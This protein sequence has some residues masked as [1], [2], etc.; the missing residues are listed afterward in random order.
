MEWTC[1]CGEIVV[2]ERG[3]CES[4]REGWIDTSA[5]CSMEW[6]CGCGEI[7]VGERGRCESTREGWID[8]SALCSMEWTCGCGE[9]V[10]GERGRCESTREGWMDTSALCSTVWTC[11]CG[12]I[13]VGER[14]RCESTSSVPNYTVR[15]TFGLVRPRTVTLA[16]PLDRTIEIGIPSWTDVRR[17]K[18]RKGWA[19][20]LPNGEK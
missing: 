7:V 3:R 14:G 8:T 15:I 5:L 11:G 10:V 16:T 20:G 18:V 13:V 17:S 9:I 4:T 1:G 2:G 6:T 19:L 12:E